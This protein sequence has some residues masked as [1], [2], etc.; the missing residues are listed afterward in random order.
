MLFSVD[1]HAIGRH[2]TG[3]E[4]YVRSLL[5]AFAAVDD[6]S[7]FVAYTSTPEASEAIP[8]RFSTRN[9]A[10]NPFARLGIDLSRQLRRDRPALIHV[11]YTAPLA[12]PVPIVVSV[13]DVSFLEHPS[14]FSA[15][16]AFQLQLTVK[17]TV[18]RA[19]RVLTVSEF[20][21][22]AISRVY[23]LDEWD[24]AVVP[25][26]AASLFRP[27]PYEAATAW[28]WRR[29]GIPPPF[30]LNVGDLQVRK[31]QA[32]LIRAF[33]EMVR[34]CPRLSHRLVLVGKDGWQGQAVRRAALEYGVGERIHFVGF[35][36]DEELLQLYNACEFFAFPSFYEG[37]GLPVVEAMACGRPVAC[38]NNSAV[39]EVADAFAILFDPQSSREMTRAMLDLALDPELR[40]RMGRLALQ[41]SGHFSWRT[42][43]EKTLQIYHEVARVTAPVVVHRASTSASNGSAGARSV[44]PWTAL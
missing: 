8:R 26:A 27:L 15:A 2:L 19:A 24:I 37:F 6:K 32:G 7:E 14:Y 33:A 13:H 20:S 25:N 30:I 23:G 4:V 21:R 29:F 34:A 3:N 28:V 42:A 17:R 36:S 41:R 10:R 18:A 5:D 16:R 1:A 39:R 35:V 12:C 38:S 44:V 11:Q 9:A 22:K 40:T 43:A 31:N